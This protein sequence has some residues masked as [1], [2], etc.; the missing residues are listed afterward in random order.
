MVYFQCTKKVPYNEDFAQSFV[1]VGI[2]PGFADIIDQ[3]FRASGDFY[4]CL[5]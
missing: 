5:F 1:R 3:I 2:F 4:T